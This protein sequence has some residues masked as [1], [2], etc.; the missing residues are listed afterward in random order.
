MTKSHPNHKKIIISHFT[1]ANVY[2]YTFLKTNHI[3]VPSRV[4]FFSHLPCFIH[5][6][7]AQ[8]L[9]L[10][11]FPPPKNHDIS[12]EK[13]NLISCLRTRNLFRSLEKYIKILFPTRGREIELL[14][15][16]LIQRQSITMLLS[17]YGKL[18]CEIF[19]AKLNLTSCLRA[20]NL[21][22]LETSIYFLS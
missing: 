3:S 9:L 19:L 7:E 2:L 8:V 13:L 11:S 17:L 10:N 18:F 22:C 20:R 21:F 1:N 12:L 6:A 15:C 5:A 16:K 14:Y 4:T